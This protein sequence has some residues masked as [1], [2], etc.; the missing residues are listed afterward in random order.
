[1]QFVSAIGDAGSD[2]PYTLPPGHHLVAGHYVL[3]FD[4]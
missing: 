3:R 4:A 1:M 2:Q